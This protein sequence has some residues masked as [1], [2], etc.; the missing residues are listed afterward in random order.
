MQRMT[1][2]AENFFA[3]LKEKGDGGLVDSSLGIAI[4]CA[5]RAPAKPRSVSGMT[6]LV[7]NKQR[8][9]SRGAAKAG[10]SASE[11]EEAER[12]YLQSRKSDTPSN[13]PD[14]IYGAVR[15]RPLLIV[16]L[17]AIGTKDEDLSKLD[18]VVAWSISFPATHTEEKLIEYVV[19]PTWLR[20]NYRDELD[21]LDEEE[22][23]GDDI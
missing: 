17:L 6:L 11:I 8:V 20:E 12:I 13:F 18:P 10:L 21:E 2:I 15:K 19:N 22:M 7:S 5:R 3:S 23:A 9:A 16:H 4:N 14:R 1:I